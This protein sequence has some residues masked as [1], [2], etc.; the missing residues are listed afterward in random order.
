ME[1]Q[2]RLNKT[3]KSIESDPI[4]CHF[5][6]NAKIAVYQNSD[7]GVSVVLRNYQSGGAPNVNWTV[8][9]NSPVFTTSRGRAEIKF[10]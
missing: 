9:V 4:D 3:N 7:T 6:E 10:Q 1:K 8:Q 5:G 2:M